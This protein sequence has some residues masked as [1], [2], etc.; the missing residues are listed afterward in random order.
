VEKEEH[1]AEKV[2]ENW[3]TQ[4]FHS[5][6]TSQDHEKALKMEHKADKKHEKM[7]HKL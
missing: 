4:G 2:S 6:P 1:K 7:E 3:L 5:R